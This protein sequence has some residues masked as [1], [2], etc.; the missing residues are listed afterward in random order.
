[1]REK[2]T[3]YKKGQITFTNLIAVFISFLLFFALLPVLQ[4]IIDDSAASLDSTSAYGQAT[5]ALMYFT[6]FVIILA[7]CLTALNYAIPRRESLYGG[8]GY[9]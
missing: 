9:G 6:P 3:G 1:M 5:I 7:L 2:N 4:P 8:G